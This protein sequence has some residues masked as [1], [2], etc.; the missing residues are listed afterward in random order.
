MNK[1]NPYR[2]R[3][4]PRPPGRLGEW[5]SLVSPGSWKWVSC[6]SEE[7]QAFSTPSLG[8]AA[9]PRDAGLLGAW[10]PLFS[11][12]SSRPGGDAIGKA[13]P[14]SSLGPLVARRE[15]R[16]VEFSKPLLLT[17]CWHQTSHKACY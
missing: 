12:F 14:S 5:P 3:E 1:L 16:K 15:N 2:G 10:G 8:G 6:S 4:G 9:G 7:K 13:D 17:A 11:V